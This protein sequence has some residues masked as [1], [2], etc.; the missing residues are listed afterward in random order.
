MHRPIYVRF[1]IL[2]PFQLLLLNILIFIYFSRFVFRLFEMW[3]KKNKKHVYTQISTL[4]TH[5]FHRNMYSTRL[6]MNT[7]FLCIPFHSFVS[8]ALAPYKNRWRKKNE[9][10]QQIHFVLF[11]INLKYLYR[12]SFIRFA[13]RAK[14]RNRN[15]SITNWKLSICSLLFSSLILKSTFPGIW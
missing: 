15:Y 8:I 9:P 12:K 5:N 6:T 11:I 14:K 10:I 13:A 2:F 3:I 7:K 1:F 4:W